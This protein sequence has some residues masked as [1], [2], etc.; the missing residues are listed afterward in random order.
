M[1]SKNV[2]LILGLTDKFTKP[3]KEVQTKIKETTGDIAKSAKKV[4]ELREQ[5]YSQMHIQSLSDEAAK[6]N[7]I[8]Y[9]ES[10]QAKIKAENAYQKE[11]KETLKEE[12]AEAAELSKKA[13]QAKQYAADW[14]KFGK[15]I[16]KSL[17]ITGGAAL[18]AGVKTGFSTGAELET[19]RANIETVTKS[20]ERA[21]QVMKYAVNMANFSAF[22][23]N[24]LIE[25]ASMLETYGLQT[26]NY[27]EAI[28]DAAA[29]TGRDVTEMSKAFGKAVVSGQFDSLADIGI[30]RDT[31]NTFAK[32]K[33]ITLFD[34]TKI[35][36]QKLMAETLKEFMNS[37]Y[38]GGMKKQ[39]T[40]M[41]GMW[42]TVSGMASNAMARMIGVTENGEI[43]IGSAMDWIRGKVENLMNTMEKWEADGTM[44]S[45]IGKIDKATSSAAKNI[46]S[47][48]NALKG[49]KS[50]L[51][52]LKPVFDAIQWLAEV[53]SG[54]QNWTLETIGNAGESFSTGNPFEANIPIDSIKD[55]WNRMP[56]AHALG[57]S[58]HTGGTALVG[59]HGPELATF[60]AGTKITSASGTRAA[61]RGN[62][63]VNIYISGAQRSDEQIAET[64]ARRVVEAL[65]SV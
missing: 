36:D 30:T 53:G 33:G 63:N 50:L 1:A 22:D 58:Y 39:A 42:S 45:I 13:K 7:A 5:M 59:E 60:P 62:T 43:R 47:I 25:S 17:L 55:W 41:S 23:N 8:A 3:L 29:I 61:L 57:T 46:D 64:V 26:E 2:S 6:K 15:V 19:L 32:S 56:I 4:A 27:L 9:N 20:S 34:G 18:T 49:I 51:E 40:T 12:K 11:L 35:K 37:R 38:A 10:T 48:F 16:T 14:K 65:A 44:E 52:P 31:L 28:G 54:I 24:E 21:S